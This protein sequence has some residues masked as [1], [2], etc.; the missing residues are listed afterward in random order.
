MVKYIVKVKFNENEFNNKL[1]TVTNDPGLRTEIH[2]DFAQ[3]IDPWTPFLTGKLHSDITISD[4]CV[5]YNVPY[6]AKKYYGTVYCKEFHPLATSY[7]DVAAM[8]VE[9]D[10][11]AARVKEMI[12]RKAKEMY[13]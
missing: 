10:A 3:T 2:Q 6:A 11:F 13:G 7:W 8:Q 9:G 12:L 4:R 1:E 5:T